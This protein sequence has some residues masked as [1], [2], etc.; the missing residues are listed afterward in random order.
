MDFKLDGVIREE[1]GGCDPIKDPIIKLKAK[2]ED[3]VYYVFVV[4]KWRGICRN[5]K[6]MER[7]VRLNTGW[8]KHPVLS[9]KPIEFV[10]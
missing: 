10:F 5:K 3:G 7:I 1:Y 6:D 8:I 9:I 2:K 4:G